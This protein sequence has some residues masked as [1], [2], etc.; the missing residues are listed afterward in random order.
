MRLDPVAPVIARRERACLAG[1]AGVVAPQCHRD[2]D[3]GEPG[4]DN[5]P[6]LGPQPLEPLRDGRT[7]RSD[8]CSATAA[9]T[10]LGSMGTQANA[11]ARSKL[12]LFI[13]NVPVR[14]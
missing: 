1:T 7:R 14:N 4:D 11:A 6:G 10:S 3:D 8:A 12:L 9:R 5:R 13:P 2:W